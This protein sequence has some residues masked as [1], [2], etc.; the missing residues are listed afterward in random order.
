MDCSLLGFS[1]DGIFQPKILSGLPFPSPG[2]LANPGIKLAYPALASRFFT[3]EPPEKP[4]RMGTS[5][6]SSDDQSLK[7]EIKSHAQEI[8]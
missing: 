8:K 7:A 1:V 3:T 5:G 6:E 2:D 4:T